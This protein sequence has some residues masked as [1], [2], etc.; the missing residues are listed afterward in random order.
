VQR[1][2]QYNPELFGCCETRVARGATS[3]GT[4][5]HGGRWSSDLSPGSTRPAIDIR[6]RGRDQ[7]GHSLR[8]AAIDLRRLVNL[9]LVHGGG[10]AAQHSLKLA[11]KPS[12]SRRDRSFWALP[13]RV[14]D[15]NPLHAD[16]SVRH[17]LSLHSSRYALTLIVQHVLAHVRSIHDWA[18][19]KGRHGRVESEL[20]ASQRRM[21]ATSFSQLR[22]AML[23]RSA[24]L[25]GAVSRYRGTERS[26]SRLNG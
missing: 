1:R 10:S 7:L 12:S 2:N 11:R 20:G 26:C 14:A 6:F 19:L 22:K 17:S 8:V 24:S 23:S 25:I 15:L 4:T 21:P 18:R 16:A 3:P 5:G 13:T 9:G